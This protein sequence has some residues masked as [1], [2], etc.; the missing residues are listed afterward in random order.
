MCCTASAVRTTSR[1][2][3][4][5]GYWHRLPREAADVPSLEGLKARLD[6]VLGSLRWWAATSSWQEAGNGFKI[7]SNLSHSTITQGQ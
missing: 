3:T 5:T 7:P 2:L 4:Q 6:G 1:C